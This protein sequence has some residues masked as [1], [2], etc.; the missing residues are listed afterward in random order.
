MRI[1]AY[2]NIVDAVK[3][4]C[5][6]AACELPG[7]ILFSLK[8][9]LIKEKSFLG[10]SLLESCIEN[11]RIAQS[12]KSPLCQDTGFAVYFVEMGNMVH[13]DGGS[14]VDAINEGT[15][16]GYTEGYLR[17]SIVEDPLFK[18][19]N[20][21]DNT[22]AV[23]HVSIVFGEDLKITL[24][25]KGG[26]S[27]NMGGIAMLKP[28]DGVKGV[29]D[30][31]VK[32]VVSAG[33]NPCPPVIVGVGIGGTME[34]AALLAKKAL[35]RNVGSF[36]PDPDYGNLESTILDS[37]NASGVGPQGLGGSTT[38]LAVHIEHFP[39]HIASLPVAVNLNCHAARHC[40][41][42]L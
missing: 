17:A 11:A 13:V 26:G 25:P 6:Q 40:T 19:E 4:M 38:A 12:G 34:M 39:C 5:I 9:S 1:V 15:A 22:P 31:V 41:R 42:M 32:T 29:V 10:R 27:E 28:A 37:I 36:N 24:A 20:T 35:L 30:F 7:D 8:A 18:R 21:R 16:A 23:V 33:G 3:E 2:K 14:V